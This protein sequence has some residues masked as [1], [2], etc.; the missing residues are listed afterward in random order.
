MSQ[1]VDLEAL[2]ANYPCDK[3]YGHAKACDCKAKEDPIERKLVDCGYYN[4]NVK[5]AQCKSCRYQRK[6]LENINK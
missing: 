6:Y 2:N 4:K 3:R 1:D 5:G